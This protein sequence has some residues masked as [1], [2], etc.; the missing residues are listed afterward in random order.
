MGDNQSKEKWESKAIPYGRQWVSPEDI[1]A[2][3]QTLEAPFL[4]TGPVA[5]QFEDG[6]CDLTGAKYAVVCT[7]GTAALHL[8]CMALGVGP[9]DIGLT[10]PNSF[11]ASANCIELCGGQADFIDIDPVS[12]CLCPDK[13]EQYC[14]N[15]PPPKVVIPVDFAGLPADLPA[16]R[17]LA[18]QYGFAV[19]EDAAHSIGSEYEFNGKF[20][21]CGSCA[22]TDLAIFSFHP[23]K[24][25]TTG[26]GGAVLTN[27]KDLAA[28]LRSLRNHGIVKMPEFTS[29]VGPWYHE[30]QQL[31]LNCRITEIQCALGISQLGR[32][33]EFKEKRQEI[34]RRYNRTF[35]GDDRLILPH[36]N[37]EKTAC[38]HL[39]PI[40]FAKGRKVRKQVHQFLIDQ[41]IFC[42]VH[43]IPIYRQPYYSDKYGYQKGKCPNADTY[44]SRCLSLPLFPA[45]T[46]AKIQFFIEKFLL[47]L[48]CYA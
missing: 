37:L 18:D 34:V 36:G 41:E 46:E 45:L 42:Q 30:M 23:V 22:H 20:Y 26:E 5:E 10:T 15:H 27:D 43:Y 17:A 40:Q 47:A 32:L 2:V 1:Q 16:I 31:S 25:I 28:R 6:L 39:Y 24:T 35:S 13:L 19:I 4:T 3:I 21:A 7:N 12:L 48:D 8:S 11:M 44:Y 14:R 33:K 29:A 9:G 38:P